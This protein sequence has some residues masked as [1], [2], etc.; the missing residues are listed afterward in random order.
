MGSHTCGLRRFR[1]LGSLTCQK[2]AGVTTKQ[3][4]AHTQSVAFSSVEGMANN[5]IHISWDFKRD[6]GNEIEGEGGIILRGGDV[7]VLHI[8]C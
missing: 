8:Q 6:I 2:S 5:K 1:L 3:A 7:K 4:R